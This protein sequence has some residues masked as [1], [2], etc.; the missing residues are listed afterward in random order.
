MAAT[1]MT[2]VSQKEQKSFMFYGQAT[3][4]FNVLLKCFDSFDIWTK[5]R[6]KPFLALCAN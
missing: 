4:F 5:G 3:P 1:L 6:I 2:K